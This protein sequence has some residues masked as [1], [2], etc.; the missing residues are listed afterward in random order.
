MAERG[1]SSM[2]ARR[3]INHLKELCRALDEG[4]RPAL[5]DLRRALAPIA[6][7]AALA[8]TLGVSGC[9]EEDP[10]VDD[11][12]A[13]ICDDAIDN[14]GDGMTDC[15]DTDCMAATVCYGVP[16]EVCDNEVDDDLDGLVD[17][18]D[19]DCA[20]ADECPEDP[21][22]EICDDAIDNDGDGM[23]DCDDTDCMAATVCYGVP[24]EECT[25]EIDD[26]MDGQVDCDDSDCIDHPDCTPLPS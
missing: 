5:F 9:P 17:C 4:R 10:P 7:P 21:P 23:T 24:F 20:S 13:E 25:N 3:I 12:I 16:F 19:D 8:L 1:D 15:D 14:D 11:P 18:D 22:V 26:D 2:D 6:L